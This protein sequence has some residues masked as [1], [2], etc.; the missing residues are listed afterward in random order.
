M[1]H[2]V[3]NDSQKNSRQRKLKDDFSSG[4]P[5]DAYSNVPHDEEARFQNKIAGGY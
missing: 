2:G 5:T 4:C 3:R 1:N